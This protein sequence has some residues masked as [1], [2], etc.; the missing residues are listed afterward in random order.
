[1]SFDF[2]SLVIFFF[3]LGG[4]IFVHEL[5]HFLAARWA[6]IEV[7]EFGFG[8]PSYKLATLFK[9]QGTEF[10]VHA[11]PLGGFVRP[12]GENDPNVPGGFGAAS[13]WKR[14]VVLFAGPVMN[15]LTAII[16][17][18]ALIAYEGVPVPGSVKIDTVAENSPAQEADIRAGDILVSINGTKVTEIEAAISIIRANL[19]KPVEMVFD[20]NGEQVTITATPLS[21]RT[22]QQ[23]AL[24][25]GLTYPTRPAT[26]VESISGGATITGIQAATIL[27]L[28]VA[29]IQGMIAPEDARLVG[30]KG[31]YDM[32]NF[33]VQ[34]DVSTR[35]EAAAVQ[36]TGGTAPKPTNRTLTLVG[37]LSISLGVFN[38]L[39]IP[40]LDG[41]R[42]VFTLPEILFRKRISPEMENMVNG[43]AMLLL[44][45]L[46][47]F[48]NVMDFINP[49][50]LPTP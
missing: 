6:G 25:V 1:M 22:A 2:L 49:A 35:Q 30:F 36:S 15:L 18:S 47:L 28:P 20:R 38:L 23:G 4:M 34:E 27:Y 5:G 48:V 46:M 7:E 43:I 50:Q 41:G 12:K 11:L 40:A 14:L 21:N 8:L 19:D 32:F 16:V 37:L 9:W 31:I 24:G 44:I 3:A 10:T 42:I 17:F 33:S 29:I 45:G 13:P 39:P 26:F